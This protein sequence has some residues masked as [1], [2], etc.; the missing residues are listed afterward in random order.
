MLARSHGVQATVTTWVCA[1]NT[2]AITV[3]LAPAF[4]CRNWATLRMTVW[5]WSDEPRLL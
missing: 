1:A 4:N 3:T 2:D 5:S